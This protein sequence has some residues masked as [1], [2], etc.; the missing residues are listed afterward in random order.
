M[1][2]SMS[3]LSL[4]GHGR[5]QALQAKHGLPAEAVEP[6]AQLLRATA[7]ASK[8]AFK[9]AAG[10]RAPSLSGPMSCAILVSELA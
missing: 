2:V 8:A 7:K 9:R 10:K 3:I 6:T 4:Q 1:P 5:A